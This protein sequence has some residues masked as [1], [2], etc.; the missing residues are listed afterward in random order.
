MGKT[1][2]ANAQELCFN[3]ACVG[4]GSVAEMGNFLYWASQDVSPE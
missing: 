2:P 1:F 4:M 3:V